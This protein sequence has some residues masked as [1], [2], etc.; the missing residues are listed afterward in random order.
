[1][2]L[3]TDPTI[4]LPD[5]GR[6]SLAAT[7]CAMAA[8]NVAAF[9][10]LRPHQRP[11]WHMF[12]V[13]LAALA[14]SKAG[15]GDVLYDEAG[16]RNVL[17]GLTPEYPD[18]E[19]WRL[20]VE[21]REA[22]AFMQPPDPGG[23]K[24]TKRSTPDDLDMLITARNHDLKQ[25]IAA[26]AEAEDWLYALVSLQTC[27]GYGGR[28]NQ[29]IAR[30]NGGSASR[31]MVGLVPR[32]GQDHGIHASQHWLRD[33]RAL[34]ARRKR[35][36][37]GALG[38]PGSDA[39]LWVI[40][41]PEGSRLQLDALDPW[42]IEVCRRVRLVSNEGK[43]SAECAN[44]IQ[45]RTNAKAFH[46]NVGDPWAPVE[47]KEDN[48]GK[49]LTI[50]RRGFNYKQMCELLYRGKWHLPFLATPTPGESGDMLLLA[51]AICRGNSK[52]EGFKSRTVP[53]P[54]TRL[55]MF[56]S[57]EVGRLAEAQ[58]KE[59][60]AFDKALRNGL[61]LVAAG[62]PRER[63]AIKKGHYS[64]TNAA[65][66]RFDRAVDAIFFPR[67]WSRA[68]AASD[69][70][71]ADEAKH[72]FLTELKAIADRLFTKAMPEMPC[73]AIHRRRAEARARSRYEA[74][75]RHEE[76][77]RALFNDLERN[78]VES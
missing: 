61:A 53:V 49:S 44:A 63:A 74:T 2:N 46:G 31:P 30:M 26:N 24:W 38:T 70:H 62:G 65:R 22:P 1:M 10:A 7:L 54:A 58:T 18:D 41:W 14:I 16:W 29:G 57:D 66:G 17:R 55:R 51:E 15:A 50:S 20:V 19:P 9:P 56:A 11:A 13:Q 28:G 35:G 71:A 3:L 21:S 33:V 40:P 36:D 59:I 72:A 64:F 75:L 12:L 39:L 47:A 8:G 67:L 76:A 27:E 60:D 69:P 77:S 23:L 32:N 68:T 5:A 34:L 25:A 37:V 4:T 48:A 73:P 43:L 78:D 42:F 45:S 52:T 6:V